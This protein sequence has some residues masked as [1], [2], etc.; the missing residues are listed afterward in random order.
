VPDFSLYSHLNRNKIDRKGMLFT[1]SVSDSA[2]V[3]LC[4]LSNKYNG[5]YSPMMKI[6]NK[7]IITRVLNRLS[8]SLLFRGIPQFNNYFKYSLDINNSHFHFIKQLLE[9]ELV[10]TGRF[11]AVTMCILTKTPFVAIES[12]TPK[13]SHLL[14]DVFG[15]NDRI[16]SIEELE[17]DF[18]KI[19]SK[20][21]I[22]TVDEK[23]KINDYLSQAENL[24]ELMIVEI[25]NIIKMF[26]NV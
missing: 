2:S 14:L 1:D 22:Y 3:R 15:K 7:N 12:N 13:I 4:D 19:T 17:R 6:V 11:H 20:R 18:K 26:K 8:R 9:A 23:L 5:T 16:F 25:K 24:V 21:N 10:I